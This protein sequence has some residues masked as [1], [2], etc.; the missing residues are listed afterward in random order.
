[1]LLRKDFSNAFKDKASTQQLST[2]KF[3]P[4]KAK[5]S[6][7]ND[8]ATQSG[9]TQTILGSAVIDDFNESRDVAGLKGLNVI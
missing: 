7:K 2:P 8:T 9:H 3:C 4:A 6:H 1:V 5:P